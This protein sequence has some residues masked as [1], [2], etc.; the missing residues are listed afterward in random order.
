M[1]KIAYP[2]LRFRHYKLCYLEYVFLFFINYMPEFFLMILYHIK[3]IFSENIANVILTTDDEN[4]IIINIK[5][6]AHINTDKNHK[7]FN[8]MQKA[9]YRYLW[10]LKIF[11]FPYYINN[12]QDYDLMINYHIKNDPE[13]LQILTI[14]PKQQKFL[15]YQKNTVY[16][17]DICFG[18][19]LY[20]ENLLSIN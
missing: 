10:L 15:I 4:Y 5:E 3:R 16:E 6:I 17:N 9:T 20:P 13:N 18:Q 14:K 12:Y 2:Y 11:E 19:I 7:Q 8:I 1:E